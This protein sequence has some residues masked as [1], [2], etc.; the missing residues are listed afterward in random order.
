MRAG[1]R[2]SAVPAAGLKLKYRMT[3]TPIFPFEGSLRSLE[4]IE[5]WSRTVEKVQ[6]L[7]N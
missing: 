5:K 3:L 4:A 6:K 1:F 2:G 7:Y